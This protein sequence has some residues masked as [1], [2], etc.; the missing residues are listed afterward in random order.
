MDHLGIFWTIVIGIIAGWL[1]GK[2]MRG[3]GFGLIRDLIL[4]VIGAFVGGLLFSAIGLSATGKIG[5][6]LMATAGALTL[7]FGLRLL[8]G[9]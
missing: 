5:H 8:R 6:L 1:S 2:I 7:L 9:K 3:R 4:G